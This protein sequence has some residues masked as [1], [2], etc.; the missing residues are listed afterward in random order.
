LT[1]TLADLAMGGVDPDLVLPDRLALLTAGETLFSGHPPGPRLLIDLGARQTG[2]ALFEGDRP[3]LIRSVFWG[4]WDLTRKLSEELNLDWL[5]AEW[6]K[7]DADLAGDDDAAEVLRRAW[8]P[9]V[10]EIDRTLAGAW[11]EDEDR[12]PELVLSGGG[13][14]TPGLQRF[15]ADKSGLDVAPASAYTPPEGS[16]IE[17]EPDLAP[18]VGL[19]AL[20]LRP[21]YQP[22]LRREEGGSLELLGRYRAPLIAL[23]AGLLLLAAINIGGLYAAYRADQR[24]YADLKDEIEQ[25]YR[26]A[27][28]DATRVVAPL[29]Q[30]RQ[31]VE[32]SSGGNPITGARGRALDILL[33]VSQAA[34]EHQGL[35]I[36]D[37]SLSPESLDLSGE[38]GSFEMVD[39]LKNQL[40]ELPYFSQATLRGARVDP[41]TKILNFRVSL[42]R[43][44]E[45]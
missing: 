1:A 43:K 36:T 22:N 37:L 32:Q 33:D 42:T 5:E 38:G 6:V 20:G 17:F 19:A 23:G 44:V 18:A 30:L 34:A 39:T 9:L 40:E 35:R 14:S 28:P 7:R 4:G 12:T 15:L 2:L 11:P 25:V 13:A 29:V 3:L 10:L 8:A 16:W 24:R 31:K 27:V 26:R 41:N 45:S 21:G